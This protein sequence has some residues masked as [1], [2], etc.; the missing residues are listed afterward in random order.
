[1]S[2]DQSSSLETKPSNPGHLL[3]WPWGQLSGFLLGLS[4]FIIGMET[5]TVYLAVYLQLISPP[6]EDG[7]SGLQMLAT[8]LALAS[9]GFGTLALALRLWRFL[10]QLPPPT[11]LPWLA[12]GG[13]ALFAVGLLAQTIA[14]C[15]PAALNARAAQQQADDSRPWHENVF[16]D[17]AIRI[18][19]PP[20]W[21]LVQNPNS[22]AS[23]IDMI[24][25][26]HDASLRATL[27]PKLDLAVQSLK[28]LSQRS[29]A[30]LAENLIDP[31]S[32]EMQAGELD[33]L[34]TIDLVQT[35]TLTGVNLVWHTRH[36]ERPD[37][38]V[39]LRMW[40]TRSRYVNHAATFDQIAASIR[41]GK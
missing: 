16:A 25:R 15:M 3:R 22:T 29:A 40:T 10:R 23:S 38:W 34:P 28:E 39:E 14:L 21:E 11:R 6:A 41:E 24:D 33:G 26:Q 5:L 4:F 2:A 31:K 18:S 36:I 30:S 1:M 35:G 32:G 37:A 27:V 19:T 8:L 7:S 17:G 13:A 20:S 12:L 9:V